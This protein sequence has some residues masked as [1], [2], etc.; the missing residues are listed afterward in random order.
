VEAVAPEVVYQHVRPLIDELTNLAKLHGGEI[1]QVLGDGFMAVFAA[2]AD[3]NDRS[4]DEAVTR[5]VRA[6]VAMVKAGEHPPGRLPVHIGIE[7]GA[8]LLSQ[9]WEPARFAVWG[10]AVTVAPRLCDL[11]GPCTLNI[12]ARAFERL[13]GDIID[14][15]GG[16]LTGQLSLRSQGLAKEILAYVVTPR[17]GGCHRGSSRR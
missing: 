17:G 11:A 5:A 3:D 8:V 10:R 2:P 12:G 7:C 14:S 9:S 1:Q 16:V 6:G 15:C 13:D 4:T